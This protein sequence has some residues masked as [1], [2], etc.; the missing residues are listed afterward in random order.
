[1]HLE[2]V[3]GSNGRSDGSDDPGRVKDL[4]AQ[5]C[6]MPRLMQPTLDFDAL[7]QCDYD[8]LPAALPNFGQG[9]NRRQRYRQ[10]VVR[11]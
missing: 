7:D 8:L 11:R 9:K 10:C 1:L 3:S 6:G 5:S 4:A 2:H